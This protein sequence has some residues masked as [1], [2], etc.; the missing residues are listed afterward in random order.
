MLFKNAMQRQIY[1]SMREICSRAVIV[2]RG[3]KGHTEVALHRCA[4]RTDVCTI[5]GVDWCG[6]FVGTVWITIRQYWWRFDIIWSHSQSGCTRAIFIFMV[7]CILV[8]RARRPSHFSAAFYY[9]DLADVM[10]NS[11]RGGDVTCIIN[12]E[13]GWLIGAHGAMPQ[14]KLVLEE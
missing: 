13:C 12:V 3:V 11:A 6:R 7:N 4:S 2:T 8:T 10:Q 14:N 1:W 9:G 5:L